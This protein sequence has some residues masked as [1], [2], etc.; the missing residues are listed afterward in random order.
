MKLNE[1]ITNLEK[2]IDNCTTP[3]EKSCIMILQ[4]YVD[5]GFSD[6]QISEYT[7]D[8][9]KSLFEWGCD[10]TQSIPTVKTTINKFLIKYDYPNDVIQALKNMPLTG[11]TNYIL[12]LDFLIEYI[13]YIRESMIGNIFKNN[14][15]CDNYSTAEIIAYLLWL[16]IKIEDIGGIKLSDVDINNMC[17]NVK[18]KSIKIPPQIQL[19][20]KQYYKAD[21]FG[22]IKNGKYAYY[23]YKKCGYFIC[24]SKGR[25]A[26]YTQNKIVRIRLNLLP[27]LIYNSGRMYVGYQKYLNG[28]NPNFYRSSWDES[29][30][31]FFELD[32][33]SA[34]QL[35][36]R[37]V[38]YLKYDW[39]RYL[40][41]QED[42]HNTLFDNRR[43][44]F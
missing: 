10:V 38:L 31:K 21:E 14:N 39:N 19:K 30:P 34:S 41:Q 12:S 20:I 2:A 13:E 24:G 18:G 36:Y 15:E 1:D 25:M 22:T 26:L 23:K 17:I 40:K 27:S 42:G 33:E 44:N 11:G 32:E 16:G 4:D 29:L 43:N 37:K 6:K 7:E 35:N 8:T 3:S 5:K 28:F 9:W